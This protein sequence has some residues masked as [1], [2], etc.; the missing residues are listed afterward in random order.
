MKSTCRDTRT[1]DSIIKSGQKDTEASITCITSSTYQINWNERYL[2]SAYTGP[3]PFELKP[4]RNWLDGPCWNL[5]DP[6][7]IGS[8]LT[9]WVHLWR[10]SHMEP[11]HSS[12]KSVPCKGYLS[13]NDFWHSDASLAWRSKTPTSLYSLKKVRNSRDGSYSFDICSLHAAHHRNR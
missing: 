10:W 11:Y 8:A 2:G 13:L 7:R 5:V 9:K 1:T 6:V 3:D 12:F 4:V